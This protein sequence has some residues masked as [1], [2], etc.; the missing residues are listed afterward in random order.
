MSTTK[1]ADN[2]DKLRRQAAAILGSIGGKSGTGIA[3]RRGDSAYYAE[4]VRKRHTKTAAKKAGA[5]AP[6]ATA[7]AVTEKVDNPD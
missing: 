5:V 3:K 2:S 7:S 4:L 1:K 6:G